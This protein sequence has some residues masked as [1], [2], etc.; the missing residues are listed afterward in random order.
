VKVNTNGAAR[1]CPG[2]AACA[3]IFRGS[4]GEYISSLFSFLR[5]QKSLYAEVMGAILAIELA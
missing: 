5:V 4:R 2:L 3:G 1:G